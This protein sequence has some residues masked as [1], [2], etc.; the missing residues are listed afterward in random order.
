MNRRVF[1]RRSL[2]AAPALALARRGFAEAPLRPSP[3]S[4]WS[5]R[6]IV[7]R[8]QREG[9]AAVQNFTSAAEPLDH[10]AWRI[11]LSVSGNQ[12]PTFNVGFAEGIPGEEM[13][14][15]WAVLSPGEPAD[16]PLAFGGLPEGWWPKQGVHLRL[17][18][19]RHRLY[20]WAHGQ[21]IVRYLAAESD[22]G[23]RYRVVNAHAACL[24][25]PA[26][27]AVSGEASVQAGLTRRAKKQLQ[28]GEGETAAPAS[29]IV[30]DA[31][32]VYQLPDGSFELYTA[33]NLEVDKTDPRYVAH[34]NTPG[35]VRVIDRLTSPA[36]LQWSGRQRVIQRTD[37]EP[38]DLQHYYL[39]VT[40]TERGR[41][42]MLGHYRVSAQTMD[43]EWCS[44]ADG[45]T[46]ERPDST[47]W[48]PR[49][50]P[51][52]LPDSYGIYAPHALVQHAGQW[53]LFYTGTTDAHNHKDSHGPAQRAILHTSTSSPW[54]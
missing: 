45:I 30:N 37:S 27:R 11:W 42:G 22:D 24:Y 6:K 5:E 2:L 4:A 15:T 39:A 7:F 48:L 18:D 21:G 41:L 50:A 16:A 44:S 52:T 9:I 40:H 46:W 28:L 43:L 17:Q 10:G 38:A 54:A 47:P 13:K 8:E 26:D 32:N 34:D 23:R 49:S 35:W 51:L 33:A 25:H 53:H 12:P 14:V 1:L 3:P 20:F 31:T 29:L 36:G 19:G